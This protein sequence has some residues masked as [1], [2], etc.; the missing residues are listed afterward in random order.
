MPRRGNTRQARLAGL[1]AA[2]AALGASAT[3]AVAATP[4][5]YSATLEQC[6]GGSSDGARS[7]SFAAEIQAMRHAA[8]MEM[9]IDIQERLAGREHFRTVGG[10]G[11]GQWRVAAPQVVAYRYVRQVSNLTAPAAYRGAVEFRWLDADG[12]VL[13]VAWAFTAPCREGAHGVAG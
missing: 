5:E 6:V 4:R 12:H 9:R 3:L 1:C 11:L 2:C 10:A 8:K 7:A 13:R